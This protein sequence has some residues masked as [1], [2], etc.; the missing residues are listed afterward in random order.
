MKNAFGVVT[1]DGVLTFGRLVV[2]GLDLRST[3]FLPS[4]ILYVLTTFSP[5][6][7]CIWRF[8]FS[9]RMLSM[10]EVCMALGVSFSDE[11]E[12]KR[13]VSKSRS[14]VRLIVILFP[15]KFFVNE[16]SFF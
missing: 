5:L 15:R 13:N 12:N 9:T 14:V 4:E 11:Q 8:A 2:T 10:G 1:F 3:G 7:K 6:R 16:Y